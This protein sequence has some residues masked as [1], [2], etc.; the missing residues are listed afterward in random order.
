[1]HP[2]AAVERDLRWAVSSPALC[3]DLPPLFTQWS[4]GGAGALAVGQ[5]LA[6]K[7][8]SPIGRYFESLIAT[9]LAAQDGVTQLETNIALQ[10]GST[11]LGEVDL[12][13]AHQGKA[14]HWELAL[15]FYLGTGSR[16]HPADWFG[17]LGRDRLD[18]KLDKLH[19]RQLQLLRSPEGLALLAE[20]G[21]HSAESHPLIKGYLFHPY[22]DWKRGHVPVPSEVD[23]MHNHGFWIHLSQATQLCQESQDWSYLAKPDWLAPARGQGDIPTGQL[24]DWLHHYFD[25]DSRPPLLAAISQGREVSRGFV[26]PDDWQ[27]Q[28][29]S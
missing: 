8:R 27:P 3:K 12:L 19:T 14:Q 25:S 7:R 13:F 16:R 10:Q 2:I 18:R 9:W 15:K 20:R 21:F 28:A 29:L 26:V 4:K 23:P 6:E 1:M 5:D 22:A 24:L 11:T 17:P